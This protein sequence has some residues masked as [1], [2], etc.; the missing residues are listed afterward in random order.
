M[1]INNLKNSSITIPQI[2]HQISHYFYVPASK[3]RNGIIIVLTLSVLV[4]VCACLVL[5]YSKTCVK[6]P[7]SK[8]PKMFFKTD[9]RL[10]QVK[11]IAEWS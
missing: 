11:S 9:Y 7:L 8:R 5:V 2:S 3:K 10:M 1:V 4:S 6:R